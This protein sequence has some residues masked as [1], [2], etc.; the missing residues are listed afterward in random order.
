MYSGISVRMHS[1][2]RLERYLL[3]REGVIVA[4]SGGVDS[5]VL[6]IVAHRALG[7]NMCAVTGDSASVPARDRQLAVDFCACHGVRHEIIA[8]REFEDANYRANVGDRCY[9]CKQELFRRLD[10]V[11]AERGLRWIAEGTNLSD[12]GGHRPGMRAKEERPNVISPYL[13]LGIDK[14]GV[15]AMARALQLDL[16]EKPATACLAS[17]IPVGTAVDPEILRRIDDAENVLRDLGLAQL[18]VRHHGTLARIEVPPDDFT[19]CVR[20]HD[21]IVARFRA[22]GYQQI[23]LDLAGYRPGGGLH[24]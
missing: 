22:L 1:L 15:R 8:T 13:D 18:R 12:L 4:F 5:A 9:F 14:E 6:A 10:V 23:T 7:G 2:E 21:L 17:R 16:A 3:A 20:H 11:R 24:G 19:R